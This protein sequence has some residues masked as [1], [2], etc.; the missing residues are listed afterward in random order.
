M[1]VNFYAVDYPVHAA[2]AVIAAQHGPGWLFVRHRERS[3]WEIPGGHWEAGER[4]EET[5]RRELYEETGALD[6]T[7]RPLAVYGV[8]GQRPSYGMLYLADVVRLG[9]LPPSEIAQVMTLTQPPPEWTYPDIQPLL[10][11]FAQRKGA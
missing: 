8:M 7:L 5:A 6:F 4:I 11:A 10:W 1:Q 2:Y 3:T 9:P